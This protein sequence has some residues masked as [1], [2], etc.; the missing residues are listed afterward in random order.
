MFSVI[1]RRFVARR[2]DHATLQHARLSGR[3]LINQG[4]R[5][6]ARLMSAIPLTVCESRLSLVVRDGPKA[7][8]TPNDIGRPMIWLYCSC[9]CAQRARLAL[10]TR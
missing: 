10:T 6:R 1:I 8:G 3:V 9:V 4:K 7:D 5:I 2:T